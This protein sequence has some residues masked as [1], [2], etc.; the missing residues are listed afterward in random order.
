MEKI[1]RKVA[2]TKAEIYQV[3]FLRFIYIKGDLTFEIQ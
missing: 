2:K 1:D 3:V